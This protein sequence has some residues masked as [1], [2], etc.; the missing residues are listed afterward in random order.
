MLYGFWAVGW[1]LL[2]TL[3]SLAP[4]PDGPRVETPLFLDK[5][6][7][8]FFYIGFTLLWYVYFKKKNIVRRYLKVFIFAGVYGTIIE[9]IQSVM[10]VGRE[11]D[12]RDVAANMAGALTAFLIL[13]MCRRY[14]KKCETKKQLFL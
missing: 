9:L 7:H 6:V 14:R 12:I 8:F 1:T 3:L 10:D 5:I 4:P 13:E 2:I 11:G